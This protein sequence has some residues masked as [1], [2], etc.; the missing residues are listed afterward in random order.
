MIM[1]KKLPIGIQTI[2]KLILGNYL[3]IDKTKMIYELLET[4]STYFLSRPR[5]FGKSLLISTLEQIFMGNK[6]LFKGLWIY[7]QAFA[8]EKHIVIRFD[9]SGRKY[10]NEQVLIDYLYLQLNE[11]ADQYG[12]SLETVRYEDQFRE[13]LRKLSKDRKVVVLIDE[14][15]KPILDVLEDIELAK[16][17]RET[18]KSFYS[19]IKASDEYLR[20]VLLT[21]VTKFS[22]VSVFSG[23]NNLNDISMNK[24]Y[25]A[26][27][28]YTQDELEYYFKER[29]EQLS[30]VIH[31]RVSD[32]LM[33]IK[34]W[35]NGYRFG[36]DVTS[37]YNPFST[38]LL[39]DN[40]A[41]SNYWFETGTPTFLVKLIKERAYD[42]TE[43]GTGELSQTGF[44]SFEIENM[45]VAPL[46][47]QTGYFTIRSYDAEYRLYSLGY[48]NYEV[49]HAFT[50]HLIGL[51][52][53]VSKDIADS[54]IARLIKALKVFDNETFFETLR[55]FFAD[56]PYD[57]QIKQEKYYQTIFYLVFT[58]IGMRIEA[59]VRTNKGRID[60]VMI[61][62]DVVHIFEF[63]LKGTAIE[64]LEQ[65]K[66]NNYYEKYMHKDRKIKMYGVAFDPA[67]KNIGEWIVKDYES[68]EY[69][70]Y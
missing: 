42:V 47:Y 17:N 38:L 66:T 46:L 5:R 40:Q 32:T 55:I 35:Y 15:D 49:G 24:R 27:L 59:E 11:Y 14:Y 30:E 6:E 21:G 56:I 29:I 25:A 54:Y 45:Q 57:I 8:W 28:G 2:D 36:I 68:L 13:L 3:Y 52:S 69:P 33:D 39:F 7:D 26:L 51:F 64:A 41:F 23:M 60:A 22:K 20:F 10:E 18:L 31:K 65:I 62:G 9:L 34:L 44:E 43:I 67:E 48:P 4:G 61:V 70:V 53:S 58:L 50:E 1:L 37:V 63:K 19:V 16:A 12:I